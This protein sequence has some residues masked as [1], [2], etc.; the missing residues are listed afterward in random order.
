MLHLA[1]SYCHT[2]LKERP[3]FFYKYPFPPN[4]AS[5]CRVWQTNRRITKNQL[6]SVLDKSKKSNWIC[7]FSKKQRWQRVIKGSEY[8]SDDNTKKA[9]L[10][11]T[12]KGLQVNCSRVKKL[13]KG[14]TTAGMLRGTVR[15]GKGYWQGNLRDQ[16]TELALCS[17]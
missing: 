14:K 13:P 8:F 4:Q 16:V 10:M 5:K 1:Q 11:C 17:V 2:T 6:D 9:S 15:L 3:C 12:C 7:L